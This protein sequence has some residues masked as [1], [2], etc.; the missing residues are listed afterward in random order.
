MGTSREAVEPQALD[1]AVEEWVC[2]LEKNGPRAVRRQ[3]ALMRTWENVSLEEAIQANVTTF[4]ES[5]VAEGGEVSEPA[6][7]M[8]AFFKDKEK[9]EI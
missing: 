6:R 9:A 3:K 7:M 8:G 5:F 2:Q 4:E 1:D